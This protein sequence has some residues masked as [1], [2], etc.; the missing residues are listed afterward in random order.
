MTSLSPSHPIAALRTIKNRVLPQGP[1]LRSVRFG[2]APGVIVPLDFRQHTRTYVGLYEV[3]LNRFLRSVCA[4]GLKSFDVG[5]Q[6]GYDA[7]VLAHLTGSAVISFEAD[8]T[9]AEGLKKT[10][11]VNGDVGALI[12][13]R[14][15]T[16]ARATGA[17]TLALDDV[18]YG[19]GFVPGIVKIDIDGGE[20]DALLGS[21]RI[22]REARPHIVVETHSIEL[23]RACGVLLHD[24][25]YQPV[26]VHQRTLWPDYRPTAHNRWLVASG[27]PQSPRASSSAYT[28]R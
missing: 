26:I 15:A 16:I 4:A 5:A 28:P 3:E 12:T 8:A 6:I 11:A 22:L 2:I 24:V 17:N 23:E 20:L 14:H 21:E 1:K 7:L 9:L 27:T 25:G 10:F 19:E 18:A 13:S